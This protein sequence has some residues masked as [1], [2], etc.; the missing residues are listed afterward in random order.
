[1]PTMITNI[2]Y[3][4]FSAIDK[5]LFFLIEV[6][7]SVFDA[8]AKVNLF[9]DGVL[10][11]FYNRVF[12]FVAIVMIFKVSFSIIQYIINPDRFSN[13]ENG[14]GKVIQGVVIALVG[15][16]VVTPIF[17]LAKDLQ[18]R[19]LEQNVIPSLI[20]GIDGGDENEENVTKKI[21]FYLAQAFVVK[22]DE[23]TDADSSKT[24]AVDGRS[25]MYVR[26][27]YDYAYNNYDYSVL[28]SLVDAKYDRNDA[29]NSD[30]YILEYRPLVSTA[31]AIFV[32]IM[33]LN[34]C[35]DVAIR[36]VKFGFLQIVAP[37][38]IISMVDPKSSKSGMM[39]KW[40]KNCLSTYA[41]LFVRIAAVSFVVYG[42]R[43]FTGQG[44]LDMN[45]GSETGSYLNIVIIFGL[46]MFAKEL[47]KLISDITGINLSGDFKMNPLKR[48]PASDKIIKTTGSLGAAGLA[49]AAAFRSNALTSLTNNKGAGKL[50]APF[51]AVGGAVSA[52][53]RGIVGAMKGEKFGKNFSN[54]YSIAMQNKKSRSDRRSDD[55]SWSEM[56]TSKIQQNLGLHTKGDAV[57]AVNSKLDAINKAYQSM[58]GAAIGND[59]GKFSAKIAGQ[60]YIIEGIKD[61]QA[62]LDIVKNT[63]IDK[64][65][66][67]DP[68][69][70]VFD[71]GAYMDAVIKQERTIHD[72]D[73]AK[74]ARLNAIAHGTVSTG[75]K[76][77]DNAI[78]GSY[79]KMIG[80]A[81]EVN[82]IT[83]S[84]DPAIGQVITSDTVATLNGTAKG[85][86][87]QVAGSS[88]AGHAKD[89]DQYGAKKNQK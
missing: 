60:M 69:T 46:L 75:D 78:I 15:L 87:A 66:F 39:S 80:L 53:G 3:L 14:F 49:G 68:K 25:L 22:K 2:F 84:I 5:V 58:E 9:N 74:K 36:T 21:P 41:G 67:V 42:I 70:N 32:V 86:T 38:P 37:I 8:I 89:V 59:K 47:P 64:S 13:G 63:Q 27:A 31:C 30:T 40:V 11:K 33:Y 48:V 72:F 16:V 55:V 50:L 54:S 28:L 56:T 85:V 10:L 17:N 26:E 19:V 51:S 29:K 12:Y 82:K 88:L 18:N 57:E 81:D 44:L 62:N 20:L 61:L 24:I 76:A 34:F 65:S 7:I 52:T 35:I 6:L 1:M 45:M 79:Q 83:K 4:F 77:T 73:E 71:E 43:E 23:F